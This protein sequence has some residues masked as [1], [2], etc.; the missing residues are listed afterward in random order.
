MQDRLAAAH[1]YTSETDSHDYKGP[2]CRFWNAGAE[3]GDFNASFVGV[4]SNLAD[5][6]SSPP[7]VT[8]CTYCENA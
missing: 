5:V 6:I 7:E 4:T 8:N 2:R 3:V 1:C